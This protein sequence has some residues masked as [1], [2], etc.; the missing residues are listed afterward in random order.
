MSG[1]P[2]GVNPLFFHPLLI[3]LFVAISSAVQGG[4]PPL[5]PLP[6]VVNAPSPSSVAPGEVV[7]SA[8][9][10]VGRL[11]DEVVMGRYQV[12][13]ERMNPLWKERTANRMGGMQELE[14]QLAGVSRQML[15]QGVSMIS[16]K[17]QGQ[18]SSF[19]VGPGKKVDRVNGQE[20]ESLIF[21]K[22]L[23]LIPTETKFRIMRQGNPKPLVVD[24]VG[25]QVAISEKGKNDWTFIDG[26]GL[27]VGDLRSLFGTL[28]SDLKLPVLQKR[29]SR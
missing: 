12:A 13:V 4:P 16:F 24:S 3:A 7:A 14:K 29:E 17:P 1:H 11:G 25:F 28:P 26:S 18:P 2:C 5:A 22:W 10:A 27:T 21:T 6:E 20:V 23:V 9:A 8:V 19:E 15:Q